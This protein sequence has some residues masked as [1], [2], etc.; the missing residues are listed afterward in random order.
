MRKQLQIFS[1]AALIFSLMIVSCLPASYASAAEAADTGTGLPVRTAEEIAAMWR[2]HM[3]PKADY[4]NPYVSAPSVNAP[5]KA[6]VL[7]SEYIQDGL[8]A[9]NFYRFI[10]GLPGDVTTSKELGELAAH[11][12]VLLAAGGQFDHEPGRPA[13]MPAAFYE[14]GL[15]STST[16]NIYSSYGYDN[17]I[18][19]ASIEAYMEDSDIYNLAEVGHRRW[20]LNPPLKLTGM[21]LAEGWVEKKYE[22]SYSATQVFDTSRKTQV[23]YHYIP[24]PARGAFPVEVMRPGTAWSVSVNPDEYAELDASKVKVTLIRKRDNRTWQF[25]SRTYAVSDKGRY[26]NVDNS[27]YGSGPAIIF[28]PEGIDEYR[29]GDTFRVRIE[30]LK[31][32]DGAGKTISYTVNFIS[33]RD[34][35]PAIPKFSDTGGHWAQQAIDWAVQKGIVSGY[36]DGT[37]RPRNT[38]TEA[39]FLAMFTQALGVKAVSSSRWSDAYY[40]FA[41]D[42][43]F[44]LRGLKDESVRSEAI[45]RTAVAELFASAAGQALT[46]REAIQYMLDNGYSKGKTSATVEGY[47]G[48]DNLTRAEAVQFIKNA[49]D[50]GYGVSY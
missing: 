43:A 12:A 27:W 19:F 13:D 32:I 10:S 24:Y 34:P 20:I 6:G 25:G 33:A 16:A 14:K 48:E 39:E 49:L 45:A 41:K 4:K 50:A 42:H 31:G 21:G 36:G 40:A 30:G 15:S 11:G 46:G 22:Y 44:S 17:H 5:Y 18:L 3:N 29:P 38:V 2:T 28:R 26:M 8:N 37:F 1:L 35:G 47:R 7:R 23:D 9:L